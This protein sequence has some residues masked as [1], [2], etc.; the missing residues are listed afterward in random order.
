MALARQMIE[1]IRLGFQQ[2]S[3]DGCGVIKIC[4]MQEEPFIVYFIVVKEWVEPHPLGGAGSANQTMDF[5][6]PA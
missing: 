5:V 4:V 6:S 3:A 2:D 1:F